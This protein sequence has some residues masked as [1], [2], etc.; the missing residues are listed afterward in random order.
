MHL[1]RYNGDLIYDPR[2][3]DL[4]IV[5]GRLSLKANESGALSLG[6]PV[7]N[8]LHGSFE[9][10]DCSR[11]VT[12]E[13]DGEEVF[14]GRIRKYEKDSLNN[15]LLECEGQLAYLNDTVV[16]PYST[17]DPEEGALAAPPAR[18]EFW[19]WLI[20]QHNAA[21]DD[22]KYFYTGT[23][24]CGDGAVE[25]SSSSYPTCASEIKSKLIDPGYGY[26]SARMESGRRYIDFIGAED[27]R[28]MQRIEFGVNL[29]DFADELSADDM[30]T[31]VIPEGKD[32][33]KLDGTLDGAFGL[34]MVSGDTIES[35]EG[36]RLH[37]RIVEH[38]SYPEAENQRALASAAAA[39]LS[40]SWTPIESLEVD[41]VDL[42][43]LDP[44]VKPLRLYDWV[45]V[46]A[47]PYGI[48]QWMMVV[49][50]EVD[51]MD[52]ASCKYTLGSTKPT[53][54][55]SNRVRQRNLKIELDGS[56]RAVA[57]LTEEA[58]AAAK[59]AAIIGE[60]AKADAAEKRR[61]FTST[62]FPPYDVGDLWVA[63][64]GGKRS[65][66][67]CT[68]AKDAD[69]DYDSQDWGLAATDD[70]VADEAKEKVDNLDGAVKVDNDSSAT[71]TTVASRLPM[72]SGTDTGYWDYPLYG[73]LQAGL[74]NYVGARF[75]QIEL[76]DDGS[77]RIYG[78][79]DWDRT[80]YR[81]PM[82]GPAIENPVE[83]GTLL[84]ICRRHLGDNNLYGPDGVT[85]RGYFIGFDD[86]GGGGYYPAEFIYN[87]ADTTV[88]DEVVAGQVTD[89]FPNNVELKLHST[90]L[91]IDTIQGQTTLN[92]SGS[93]LVLNKSDEGTASAVIKS[94]VAGCTVVIGE[95][96]A[97]LP[98]KEPYGYF[99]YSL[100]PVLQ[101]T[102][103]NQYQA[104]LEQ[105]QAQCH[106]YHD[107]G[108]VT[109]GAPS[110]SKPFTVTLV[111]EDGLWEELKAGDGDA[112]DYGASYHFFF[113]GT[114]VKVHYR[115]AAN[116]G[117]ATDA[118]ITVSTVA[119]VSA[120]GVVYDKD[121]AVLEGYTRTYAETPSGFR[122][123]IL[124]P[125][126]T[127]WF[128]CS[129]G[130]V[131]DS[132]ALS[133]ADAPAVA[134]PLQKAQGRQS[135]IVVNGNLRVL[136]DVIQGPSGD[137]SE[138]SFCP[139]PVGAVLQ[140]VNE[141][142]PN[143][144][145]QGTT[146]Q[147]IEGRFLLAS[148]DGYT[149]GATGGEAAHTL[150]VAEMA[151]HTHTMSS[152]GSHQHQGKCSTYWGG[153]VGGQ[154]GGSFAGDLVVRTSNDTAYSSWNVMFDGGAHTHTNDGAGGGAAHNNMPPY[155]VVNTWERT[156]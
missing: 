136:G 112:S 102:A 49:A 35:A 6:I 106:S 113:D 57:A 14:R 63:N 104:N 47:K 68:T 86:G 36:V 98:S 64:E 24:E 87:L 21:A 43:K 69:G 155:K 140:M 59:D 130:T 2:R 9:L 110:D 53:L 94:E 67:T 139:W 62:P 19:A 127:S 77:E 147:K 123:E 138:A 153:S 74:Q 22:G 92:P 66:R 52:P 152:A 128:L 39:D 13:E 121:G 46:T 75:L 108:L 26:V 27:R 96:C 116:N 80:H 115:D 88:S 10:M 71:D 131:E 83:D 151:N 107:R 16:R 85:V 111:E 44:S 30:V 73:Q 109:P 126:G 133:E 148:G 72:P 84:Y 129:L 154:G 97:G 1:V 118:L 20:A 48:D 7:T 132:T 79:N 11:E 58:K 76:A 12:V 134:L 90:G 40:D 100:A 25:A 135:D 55:N 3:T 78:Y 125:D 124:K 122:Y 103:G 93:T 34:C 29:V 8:P 145:Y 89:F 156:A 28:N 51:I 144:I 45:R 146:W 41:A 33:I 101:S 23:N 50:I 60:E 99:G 137:S 5:S 65:I 91:S 105:I 95:G 18:R 38:R 4:G 31:A 37:G 149:L 114:D 120:A 81:F 42:H 142:N 15:E 141:S 150:T 70:T 56:I 82:G 32:G 143:E 17:T 61:V 119:R 54:T 117:A